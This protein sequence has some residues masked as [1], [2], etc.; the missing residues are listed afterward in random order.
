M[1]QKITR[2]T[3]DICGKEAKAGE[4]FC[5]DINY[6]NPET[7]DIIKSYDSQLAKKD[8]CACCV[9]KLL[10][11]LNYKKKII[12][13]PFESEEERKTRPKSLDWELIMNMYR[14]GTRYDAIA[15]KTGGSINTIRNGISKR[16]RE[17]KR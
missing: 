13:R 4:V 3:C 14:E 12:K 7:G 17:E 6:I 10:E 5:I 2:I 11:K 15:E 8:V 1:I 16:L 9:E